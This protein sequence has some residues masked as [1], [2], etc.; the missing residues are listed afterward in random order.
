MVSHHAPRPHGSASGRMLFALVDALR[1]EGHEA[2]VKC[3]A[4]EQPA[5]LPTWAEWRP[6]P[7]AS[8]W[9]VRARALVLPRSDVVRMH[10]DLPTDAVLVADDTL[11]FPA[12]RGAPRTVANIHNS[13]AL[14]RRALGGRS[15]SD[16]QDVRA[17][18]RVVRQAPELWVSSSRVRE[19]FGRGVVVPYTLPI[20]E[21][22][23]APVEVP[24]VG[25]LADW[26]WR[27][28]LVALASLL[29]SWPQVRDQVPGAQLLLAGR[30]TAP[31]GS[32]AGV[33]DLGE[34]PTSADLLSQV[35]LLAFPC[36]PSSGAKMKSFDALAHGVALVTTS[37]GAEGL[38][39]GAA[40]VVPVGSSFGDEL[41]RL[42]R[43]VPAR[44]ELARR[45][46]RLLV[47]HHSPRV[48]A[49]ARVDALAA[50]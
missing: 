10:W 40:Q 48:A 12:V 34:V 33:R 8:F 38:P 26:R 31:V 44:Q 49:L 25:M 7:S 21:Q 20:P 1:A 27:P 36:P 23:G 13:L 35:A 43:D 5:D 28:N 19:A 15:G 24:V 30:G 46:R 3:W 2:T 6:L 39:E 14:D 37:A 18:R 22:V 29:D 32:V 4:P 11:S 16:L 9:A 42:L 47:E 41:V 17:E 50:G 45:G